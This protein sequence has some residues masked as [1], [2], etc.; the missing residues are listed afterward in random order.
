M[1]G[2]LLAAADSVRISDVT[3]FHL[4]LD[5]VGVLGAMV[6]L[7]EYGLRRLA[8]IHAPRGEVVV[9]SGQRK[10]FYA[11]ILSLYVVSTW[12]V[13]DIGE[14][15]LFMFH[16]S[17]HLVFGLVAPPLLLAGTPWWLIR[18]AV[19]PVLPVL[20]IVTKPLVALALFNGMLG[21]IHVPA[22]LNLMLENEFAHFGLH[23][24]LFVT[25]IF[26]W[27]PILGPIPDIP[28]LSP[29]MAMG[30]LFLQSLVP[31]IPATFLTFGQSPLYPIYET[32]P[33]LWGI[34][35]LDDQI[36][37]GLIM[38]L[39]AGFL[40]W[41]YIAWIWFSWWNDEQRYNTATPRVSA[42]K[43]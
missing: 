4:H 17:E 21:L 35:A 28:Q 20:K 7:Y 34:S 27:W 33:R 2:A 3:P 19:K 42:T 38:K 25:G 11:G 13:H 23:G 43:T 16:M 1:L 37:A 5:V 36:M 41:G 26:M 9:T 10:A 32:F 14:S 39:G 40:L 18:L 12:P 22:V 6:V 29:F 8:P 15:S 30:Y 31:T 24:I